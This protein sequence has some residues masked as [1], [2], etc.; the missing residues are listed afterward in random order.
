MWNHGKTTE[1][2]QLQTEKQYEHSSKTQ[3]SKKKHEENKPKTSSRQQYGDE[4]QTAQHGLGY[5][6]RKGLKPVTRL[7]VFFSF[8]RGV[9]WVFLGI[10]VF[11]CRPCVRLAST[12]CPPIHHMSTHIC[13]PSVCLESALAVPPNFARHVPPCVCLVSALSPLACPLLAC[14]GVGPWRQAKFFC[15]IAQPTAFYFAPRGSL[16][17]I[18]SFLLTEFRLHKCTLCLKTWVYAGIVFP[19]FSYGFSM[20]FHRVFLVVLWFSDHFP[21]RFFT[22]ESPN[23]DSWCMLKTEDFSIYG[24]FDG[25]GQKGHDVSNFVKA[26]MEMVFQKR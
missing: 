10:F 15:T 20:C 26:R 3:K 9:S 16:S 17:F 21:H 1:K 12:M 2:K 23:Q 11:M 18:Y 7:T 22:E 25:H 6:C 24:V 19:W 14:C 8:F 13:P 5:T 4:L